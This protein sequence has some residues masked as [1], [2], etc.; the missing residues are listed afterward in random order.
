VAVRFFPESAATLAAQNR[1]AAPLHCVWGAIFFSG[2]CAVALAQRV[3]LYEELE[4]IRDRPLIVYVNS[5]RPGITSLM[6]VDDIPELLDQLQELPANIQAADFLIV[7]NG[8]DATVAWRIMTLLRERVKKVAV[9]VPQAAFSA[10][11]LFALGADEIVMHPNGNLGPV[12]PQIEVTKHGE[13]QQRFG[14]EELASFLEFARKEVGLTDQDHIRAMFELLCNQVGTVPVGVAARSS[15]LSLSM[16]EKLLRMHM[17]GPSAGPK[18]KTIAE[19]LNKAFY[20][21]GY[22]VG[23][24]EAKGLGLKVADS[25]TKIESLMWSIWLD[26][27]QELEM[28]RPFNPISE[29]LASPQAANLLAPVP[30]LN[31]PANAPPQFVQQALQQLLQ[32][33]IVQVE[34]VECKLTTSVIESRRHAS[35]E[36]MNGRLLACRMP[37][38]NVKVALVI[39]RAGWERVDIPP[40]A[41]G[42]A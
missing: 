22:P 37:D 34:P 28:R 5:K 21:H 27:E 4:A 8:G 33:S 39:E 30:Q 12:D 3:Q 6:G 13:K 16:G 14:F 1:Q 29:V 41:G 17:T 35:R 23:R 40:P 9:L 20:H 36:I 32:I 10:A 26:I 38:L 19:S 11:T 7:S 42:V 31:L 18:A 2:W 15:L 24:T 25:D